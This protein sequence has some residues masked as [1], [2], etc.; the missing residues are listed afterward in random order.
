MNQSYALISVYDKTGCLELARELAA[1]QIRILSTGGTARYLAENGLEVIQVSDL[2]QFPEIFHGRVKTLHPLIEG[3][4]LFR[5]EI[6]EDQADQARLGIPSID[7]VICNLYPFES[8]VNRPGAEHDEIIENIDIGGPTMLRAAAK[9]YRH[10]VVLTRSEDYL[11]MIDKLKNGQAVTTEERLVLASKAFAHTSYYDGLIFHYLNREPLDKVP[12]FSLPVRREVE[13]RYGENPHQQACFFAKGYRS[14]GL[15][16]VQCHGKELSYNN[17]LD[18]N[19]AYQM[20]GEFSRP[21]AVIIKHNNPCGLAVGE[22]IR[23]AFEKARDGDPLS[24]YGGIIAVNRPVEADLAELINEFFNECLLAPDYS[25]QAMELLKKKK[26][27]RVLKM[28]DCP[29][30]TYPTLTDI[31]GGFLMQ[32]RDRGFPELDSMQLMS[33]QPLSAGQF[34]DIGLALVAVKYAKSNAI[35]I[36]NQG[37]LIGIGAG[38]T[39]RVDSVKI[40]IRK[41]QEN[42][43][44]LS[45]AILASDAFFPFRDNIDYC[46][47][48]GLSGIIQPG[49]S[50]RDEEVIEAARQHGISMYFTQIRHFKH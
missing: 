50:T 30:E 19:V 14:G 36:V 22:T 6:P 13:L 11:F 8:V 7:Y 29:T 38:Q 15:P 39:S 37:M 16:Y 40:A 3:G 10:V 41:S 33:G 28:R 45:G 20:I 31:C 42:Q 27:R 9:N 47:P 46:A 43:H 25:D 1:R 48:Y 24:A 26:N 21:A 18:M 32:T 44:S 35:T 23:Q 4:I 12:H 17:M 49:G 34:D 5:R 2:T